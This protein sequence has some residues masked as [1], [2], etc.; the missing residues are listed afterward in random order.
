M[1]PWEAT[2]PI[3]IKEARDKIEEAYPELKPVK[4]KDLG[5][6]FDHTV[7]MVNEQWVFRFP[8]R[9]LGLEA[10][11]IENKVL[12]SLEKV[13]FEGGFDY[14]KPVYFQKGQDENDSY[15]G[16]SLIEGQ[17]L[18]DLEDTD[19]LNEAAEKLGHFLKK[20][21]ALPVECIDA[22]PDHLN[23]LSTALRRKHFYVIAE[24]A[25]PVIPEKLYQ[26]L[27]SYLDQLEEWENPA[28]TVLVHGDLHP[29]N[30]IAREGKLAGIIDWGDAHIGHP[31]SDL[32]IVF[33]CISHEKRSL[34]FDAYGEV[35]DETIKLARFKA[36]FLNTVLL[37]YAKSTNDQNV[38]R[39]A[40]TGLK[41]SLS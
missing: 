7:Y 2:N 14:P 25:A 15:V 35:N 41:K 17:V 18:T 3:T 29:K 1:N 37:R 39:W 31:A 20:L 13:S 36:A 33:Q 23:R 22:G 5:T 30:L 21:H 40:L 24:E 34:F 19:C 9:K 8:R 27:L 38:L 10:M 32:S 4:I 26:Q 28:G 6:G 16:F 12:T 11:Y